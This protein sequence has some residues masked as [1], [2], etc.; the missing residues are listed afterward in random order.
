MFRVQGSTWPLALPCRRSDMRPQR[1]IFVNLKTKVEEGGN[2]GEGRKWVRRGETIVRR[3][4]GG[5]GNK[6][7]L[8]AAMSRDKT[9]LELRNRNNE[10]RSARAYAISI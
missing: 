8:I 3:S 7:R 2:Q 9:S 4:R 10:E 1:S 5:I 6:Q